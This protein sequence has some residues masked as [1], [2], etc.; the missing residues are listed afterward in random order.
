LHFLLESKRLD[1]RSC[2]QKTDINAA[3]KVSKMQLDNDKSDILYLLQI[4]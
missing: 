3:I 1:K 2:L 4:C